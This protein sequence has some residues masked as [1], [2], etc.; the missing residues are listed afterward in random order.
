MSQQIWWH[1]ARA[2]GIVTWLFIT[3]S[4]VWG[5]L[6]STDLFARY[7]R[8]SWLLDLHR[9]LGGLSVIGA[10]IHIGALIADSWVHFDIVDVLVP[11]AS[12]WKPWQVALG[13][14]A[15]WGLV[16]IQLTSLAMKQLPKRVWRAIHLGSYGVFVAGSLHGIVTGTDAT[17]RLYAWTSIVVSISVMALV[18]RRIARPG[19]VRGSGATPVTRW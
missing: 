3:A 13:V 6:L 14:T 4:V 12:D 15:F 8:R 9:A 7:R 16:A 1:L 18:I 11:F 10:L 2:S 5:I 17:G 19:I